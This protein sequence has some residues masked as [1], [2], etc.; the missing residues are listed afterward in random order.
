MPGKPFEIERIMDSLATIST[1][2]FKRLHC[3]ECNQCEPCGP[4]FM[5]ALKVLQEAGT[6]NV[7]IKGGGGAGR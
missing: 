1:I 2:L 7:E 6:P 5:G 4:A 3:M